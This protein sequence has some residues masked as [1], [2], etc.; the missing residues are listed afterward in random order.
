MKTIKTA[1]IFYTL[2]PLEEGQELGLEYIRTLLANI[3]G[4]IREKMMRDKQTGEYKVF[5]RFAGGIE[6][7]HTTGIALSHKT[8]PNKGRTKADRTADYPSS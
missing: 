8:K 4:N 3:L 6:V 5:R 7:D 2:Q 1:T